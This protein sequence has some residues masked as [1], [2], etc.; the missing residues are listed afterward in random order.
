[1]PERLR[2]WARRRP[3][4]KLAA[5]ENDLPAPGDRYLE[6]ETCKAFYLNPFTDWPALSPIQ[7]GELLA[8]ECHRNLREAYISDRITNKPKRDPRKNAWDDLMGRY[9]LS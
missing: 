4:E 8:H 7:Q 1:M 3:A 9:G 6:L 5:D 2:E